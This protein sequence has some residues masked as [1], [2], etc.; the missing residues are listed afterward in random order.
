MKLI[1]YKYKNYKNYKMF[2]NYC[3]FYELIR[4]NN[5]YYKFNII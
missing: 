4:K 3:D 5:I 2:I 1:F